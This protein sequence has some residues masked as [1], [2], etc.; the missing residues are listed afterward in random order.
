M[1]VS[2]RRK[3][4]P[5]CQCQIK[6]S[7][8]CHQR[9]GGRCRT[10]GL[11]RE[12]HDE[13]SGPHAASVPKTP[14]KLVYPPPT[15]EMAPATVKS[16]WRAA[17]RPKYSA[18]SV[19]CDWRGRWTVR[20]GAG[21]RARG[22]YLAVAAARDGPRWGE[23]VAPHT[24]CGGRGRSLSL[25][26]ARAWALLLSWVLIGP[27]KTA[28][29]KLDSGTSSSQNGE[30]AH[31]ISSSAQKRERGRGSE[32]AT[33]QGREAAT[34]QRRGSE[35]ARRPAGRPDR[36]QG[37]SWQRGRHTTTEPKPPPTDHL[38]SHRLP[39]RWRRSSQG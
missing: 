39:T 36:R 28:V 3:P 1:L 27:S 31:L 15:R 35:A 7:E 30:N 38:R 5:T 11:A 19:D 34:E 33:Q 16:A 24:C 22:C 2:H 10:G 29:S 8:L 21:V 37:Q 14:S 18:F 17:P 20:V 13:A 4:R 32:A 25:A 9:R 6:T 23:L 26:W 12:R